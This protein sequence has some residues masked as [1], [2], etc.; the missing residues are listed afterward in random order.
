[1]WMISAMCSAVNRYAPPTHGDPLGVRGSAGGEL[2]DDAAGGVVAERRI[3]LVAV[4]S[5]G[6]GAERD[7]VDVGG[8]GQ[9]AAPAGREIGDQFRGR[10]AGAGQDAV[11]VAEDRQEPVRDD[12]NRT[13]TA[14][15]P[16]D[17]AAVLQ[18]ATDA[19]PRV[20]EAH[21]R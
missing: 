6:V 13:E 9:D 14:G 2:G 21:A 19:T 7:L 17:P 20:Q 8:V 5:P 4:Q 1:M 3:D 18:A 16:V 10:A 15:V 12:H 11:A